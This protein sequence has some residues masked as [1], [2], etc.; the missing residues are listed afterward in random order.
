MQRQTVIV[1]LKAPR[2]GQVKTRL[3]RAIGD[4]AALRFHRETAARLIRALARDRRWRVMLA[5][6]PRGALRHRDVP[7]PALRRVDQGQGDLGRRMARAL[8]LAGR[9]AVLVGTDIPD[10]SPAIVAQAFRALRSHD[11][12]LGPAEDGGY[13][14]VGVNDPALARFDGVRWSTRHA[15]ADTRAKLANRRVALLAPLADID[16][17]QD[18]R[19]WRSRSR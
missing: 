11:V 15:L 8:R 14:L 1:F 4:V 7:G 12:V 19:R 17:P 6:S 2:I 18:Y 5:L 9:P 13:W 10:L 3:A 16:T